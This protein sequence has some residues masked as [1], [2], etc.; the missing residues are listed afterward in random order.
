MSQKMKEQGKEWKECKRQENK[1]SVV[2][3][4]IESKRERER[5]SKWIEIY[6]GVRENGLHFSS[7]RQ[8]I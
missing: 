6:G 4:M 8:S 2:E 1:G 3:R 7:L 5:L